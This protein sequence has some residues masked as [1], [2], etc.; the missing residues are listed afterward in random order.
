[1]RLF[2]AFIQSKYAKV[3]APA[4]LVWRF[5]S[6]IRH[7]LYDCGILTIHKVPIA[8]VSIGNI[9]AGGRGKT[10]LVI[11]LGKVFATHKVAILSRGYGGGDE[12]KVIRRH[13]SDALIYEHPN[14][15]ESARKAVA[16]GAQLILLD[17]GF[18]HRRLHRD[19]DVVLVQPKDLQGRCIPAGELRDP[20]SRLE[21]AIVLGSLEKTATCSV[22]LEG[23]PV[24]IFCGIGSPERF[25]KTVVE[26]GALIVSELYLGDHEP[27][28]GTRLKAFYEQS[29]RL[30]AKYLLCTEKDE[31]KLPQTNYPIHS[32]R[33]ETKVDGIENLIE[34]IKE[35]L[36]N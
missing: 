23:V 17:D 30:G 28:G 36:N 29:I 1:M 33:I 34:K 14:R 9:A 27:I 5:I 16:D 26:L 3:L 2:E 7:A 18:Q 11:L 4:G 22:P 21:K 32:V 6:S 12:A 19:F 24:S 25:K 8:V 13:L 35:R 20:L 15:V 31:V 10:P